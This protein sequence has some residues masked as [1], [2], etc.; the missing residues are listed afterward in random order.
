ML[1]LKNARVVDYTTVTDKIQDI[2]INAGEIIK[3]SEN[4]EAEANKVIDCAGLVAIPGLFDMHV[5]ARDPGQTHK[6]NLLTCAEA[7]A[8]GGVTGFLCMPN[9]E[10]V[11]DSVET[12]NYITEKAKDC[13]VKIHVSCAITEKQE[14]KTLCDFAALAKAGAVAI[15]DDGRPV[16]SAQ[17]MG[18]AIIKGDD[19]KLAVISHCEDLS[20]ACGG[21]MN[22][23]LVS[24][25]LGVRGI[26][27]SS[28]NIMTSRE[29][30]LARDLYGKVHI[31]HVSTKE[32]CA[33]IRAAKEE[34][35]G[36]TCE[37]A[38]HY[39]A[40][41]EEALRTRDADYRMNPPLRLQAD[42]DA[43]IEAIADKTIDCIITDHAPHSPEEKADFRSAPNGVIGL[44]TSL[45]ATLTFLYHTGKIDL[46][47]VVRLMC[48]NPRRILG[49]D[50]GKL[51][52]GEAA[53][54]TLFNPDEEWLV[55]P[56]KFKSKSRNSCFKGMKLKGRVKYT[57]VDGEVVYED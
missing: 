54:I 39:F 40:L 42:V 44:E 10:P 3:I 47:D 36:V 50:G 26:H 56:E 48:V 43:I 45:A 32:A 46:F 37:T 2:L 38:P 7:A 55:E 30:D 57:I 51:E 22:A 8:A 1:L 49:I 35:V 23:G 15:T 52:V 28:E 18:E 6:E 31:A 41:T 17:L 9:T 16:K 27:R 33:K 5:H 4:I 24:I 14:G 34:G 29:I 20:I 25:Q 12:I 11:I 13:K 19:L 53:D 21:A